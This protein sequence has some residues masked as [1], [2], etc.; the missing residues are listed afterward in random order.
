MASTIYRK[1]LIISSSQPVRN[2]QR[3]NVLVILSCESGG[4]IKYEILHGPA[5]FQSEAEAEAFGFQIGKQWLDEH[6][7]WA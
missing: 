6:Y 3:W 2:T 5:D 4:K 1:C 7:P